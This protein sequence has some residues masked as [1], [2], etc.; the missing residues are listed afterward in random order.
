MIQHLEGQ[1]FSLFPAPDYEI[2][3]EKI[4]CDPNQKHFEWWFCIYY[5]GV[6]HIRFLKKE[7]AVNYV[8]GLM[9][10]TQPK[11][12]GEAVQ[13]EAQGAGVTE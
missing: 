9:R 7:T 4:W 6:R 10:G 1:Q 11:G 13:G 5:R 3:H 2:R 12:Q 8:N